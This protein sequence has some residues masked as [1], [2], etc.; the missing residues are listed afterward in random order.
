MAEFPVCE[1]EPHST[2]NIV[3]YMLVHILRG[4]LVIPII[5]A[6]NILADKIITN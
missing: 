2:V 6:K 5:L 3:V 4:I 1:Y